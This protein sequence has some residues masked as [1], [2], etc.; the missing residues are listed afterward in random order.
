[1]KMIFASMICFFALLCPSTHAQEWIAMQPSPPAV[2]VSPYPTQSFST[3][4]VAQYIRPAVYQPVP[5]IVNQ[6]VVVEHSG[7]F[8][9]RYYVVNKPQVQWVYQLVFVNP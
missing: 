1:M 9:K 8:W 3:F 2:Y 7:L 4:P 6:Q 5:F